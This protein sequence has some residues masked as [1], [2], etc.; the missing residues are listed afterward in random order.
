MDATVWI[1]TCWLRIL[2]AIAIA[3]CQAPSPARYLV[4][5]RPVAVPGVVPAICVAVDPS[6]P[7]GVWHW[8]PVGSDCSRRSTGPG[9]FPAHEPFVAR[10]ESGALRAGLRIQLITHPDS[11][12]PP[13]I[14]IRLLLKDAMMQVVGTDVR[15]PIRSRGDLAID[16]GWSR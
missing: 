3:G 1:S 6:D 11:S 5:D 15:V 2:A 12:S 16:E 10:D 13:F 7:K 4:S 14:D 8:G 9:V